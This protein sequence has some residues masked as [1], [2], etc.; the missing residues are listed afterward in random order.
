[1]EE[2]SKN[3][4]ENKIMKNLSRNITIIGLFSRA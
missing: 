2:V 3:D 1:M 4:S